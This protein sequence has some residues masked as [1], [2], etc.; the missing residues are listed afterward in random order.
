VKR[1]RWWLFWIVLLLYAVTVAWFKLLLDH[2]QFVQPMWLWH[3]CQDD[4]T[5]WLFGSRSLVVYLS[6]CVWFWFHRLWL[7]RNALR[8]DG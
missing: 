7:S 5:N 4:F 6:I 1:W 3:D 2:C 8:N